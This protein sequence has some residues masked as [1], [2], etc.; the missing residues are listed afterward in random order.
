MLL[1][2]RHQWVIIGLFGPISL[3]VG[4]QDDYWY[5]LKLG[6]D[7]PTFFVD[8]RSWV[9]EKGKKLQGWGVLHKFSTD[10]SCRLFKLYISTNIWLDE[11][12]LFKF[13]FRSY[14]VLCQKVVVFLHICV[15]RAKLAWPFV[16]SISFSSMQKQDWLSD[17]TRILVRIG[18]CHNIQLLVV[19]VYICR[20]MPLLLSP[21]MFLGWSQLS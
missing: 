4:W 10:K 16:L 13:H 5:F 12:Y 14:C 21:I 3:I 18:N 19:S 6:I 7:G 15:S 20:K 8:V 2:L 17:L 9:Q 11:I 1:F